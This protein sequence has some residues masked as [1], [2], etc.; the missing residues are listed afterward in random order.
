MQKACR[1]KIWRNRVPVFSETLAASGLHPNLCGLRQTTES[2]TGQPRE[3]RMIAMLHFHFHRGDG[4]IFFGLFIA[5]LL[6]VLL[7]AAVPLERRDR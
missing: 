1:E 7:I 3:A 4:S 6:I 5:V 2:K